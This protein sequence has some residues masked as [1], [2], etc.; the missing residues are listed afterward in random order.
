MKHV[1]DLVPLLTKLIFSPFHT[2]FNSLVIFFIQA[3]IIEILLND[4]IWRLHSLS[5]DESQRYV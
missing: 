1:E 2:H 5:L 4:N 3:K